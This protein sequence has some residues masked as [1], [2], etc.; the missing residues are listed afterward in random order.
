[1]IVVRLMLFHGTDEETKVVCSRDSERVEEYKCE[2]AELTV[3][4]ACRFSGYRRA[5]SVYNLPTVE[6]I[7]GDFHFCS[8]VEQVANISTGASG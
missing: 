2:L 3:C 6:M 4:K 7:Y 8:M 1:M 5:R